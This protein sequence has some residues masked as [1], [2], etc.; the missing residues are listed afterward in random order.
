[1][2]ASILHEM[3]YIT[4]KKGLIF[5]PLGTTGWVIVSVLYQGNRAWFGDITYHTTWVK[6]MPT[7]NGC[8]AEIGLPD[9]L[10]ATL[11]ANHSKGHFLGGET[12]NRLRELVL[13]H[14]QAMP[15]YQAAV[16]ENSLQQT[17]EQ[18]RQNDL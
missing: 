4:C 17:L 12:I 15:T 3:G 7:S 13:A 18:I 2:K 6:D 9:D 16:A 5:L 10:G 11:M 1:M 8:L 14:R